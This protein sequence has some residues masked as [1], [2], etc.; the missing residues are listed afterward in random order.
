[1]DHRRGLSLPLS[2]GTLDIV[3]GSGPKYSYVDFEDKKALKAHYPNGSYRPGASDAPAGRISFYAAGS[4]SVDLTTAK[5]ATF[6][7]LIFFPDGFEWVKGG[8]L[9]SFYKYII[10]FAWSTI[11]LRFF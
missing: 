6:S 8:K 9:P 1:M 11:L 4:Q 2:D 3:H 7:Y 5:E 10:P